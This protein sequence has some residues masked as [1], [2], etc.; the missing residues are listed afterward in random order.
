MKL[1]VHAARIPSDKPCHEVPRVRPIELPSAS[2]E[3]GLAIR[4]LMKVELSKMDP[5]MV[6]ENLQQAKPGSQKPTSVLRS[7][8]PI[9]TR[10]IGSCQE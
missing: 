2:G 5:S 1:N 3:L 8:E 4:A 10:K 6:R 7:D 9:R